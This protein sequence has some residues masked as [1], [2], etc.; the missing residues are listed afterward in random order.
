MWNAF[1]NSADG[2]PFDS[3]AARRDI[4]ERNPRA[5]TADARRSGE[6]DLSEADRIDDDE[7][8]AIL[9][10]SIKG[11]DVPPPVRSFFGH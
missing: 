1:R 2:K 9:W 5:T 4:N 6:F 3:V 7:M 10:H 11:G 8:N